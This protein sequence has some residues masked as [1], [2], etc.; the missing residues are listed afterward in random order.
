MIKLLMNWDIKPGQEHAYFEFQ[1]QELAPS[2][3][4]MGLHLSEAW[5]TV[6][7]KGPRILFA[8]VTED[9]ESLQKILDSEEWKSL[10]ERLLSFVT[11]YSH[12]VVAASSR[13]QM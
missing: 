10:H 5:Y 1:V 8:S 4:Q 13:F 12:K 9:L 7:G 6:Y 3:A 2:M 11:N